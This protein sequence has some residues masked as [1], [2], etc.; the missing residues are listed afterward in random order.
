MNFTI[1]VEIISMVMCRIIGR[2]S[3]ELRRDSLSGG[4]TIYF[5]S[6]LSFST[7]IY[8]GFNCGFSPDVRPAKAILGM[9]ASGI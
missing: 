5:S 2:S 6:G 8:E 7:G 9:R 3:R 1:S 4:V